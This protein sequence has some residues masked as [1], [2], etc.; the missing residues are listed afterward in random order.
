MTFI[1]VPKPHRYRTFYSNKTTD[2][3]YF[4]LRV[5]QFYTSHIENPRRRW[6]ITRCAVSRE[7]KKPPHTHTPPPKKQQ[8]FCFL[9]MMNNE[10]PRAWVF[11]RPDYT[12]KSI[13]PL[14]S[15]TC[16]PK[17]T[18]FREALYRL[19]EYPAPNSFLT[20]L[21]S[22]GLG[23]RDTSQARGESPVNEKSTRVPSRQ[24]PSATIDVFSP[25]RQIY[26]IPDPLD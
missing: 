13:R 6:I 11:T 21:T 17:K 2:K 4:S 25:Y 5:E 1:G 3:A 22:I 15:V 26:S 10:R 24:N 7:D 20:L 8:H 16:V 9:F 23:E 19:P 14:L 12:T 18:I